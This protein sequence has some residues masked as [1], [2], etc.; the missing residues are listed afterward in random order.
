MGYIHQ[1][2]PM[3]IGY[4]PFVNRQ[5]AIASLQVWRR[6]RRPAAWGSSSPG[7]KV[8]NTCAACAF[9]LCVCMYIYIYTHM[10]DSIYKWMICGFPYFRKCPYIYTYI[11]IYLYIHDLNWFKHIWVDKYENIYARVAS[12]RTMYYLH[13]CI[14]TNVF[15]S[16]CLALGSSLSP[17]QGPRVSLF[18]CGFWYARC[19]QFE[20]LNAHPFLIEFRVTPLFSYC[21]CQLNGEAGKIVM[22][23]GPLVFF[24]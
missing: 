23:L 22:A 15:M 9:Y 19:N 21:S 10:G 14:C 1:Y 18:R 6:E 4:W 5:P 20:T 2:A 3:F 11:S 7:R 8:C 24:Q 13:G 16:I 12:V 17:L